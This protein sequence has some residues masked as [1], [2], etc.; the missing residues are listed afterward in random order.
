MSERTDEPEEK[1]KNRSK[2]IA[3]KNIV[4]KQNAEHNR[5]DKSKKIKNKNQSKNKAGEKTASESRAEKKKKKEEELTKLKKAN[6]A[7]ALLILGPR[8]S[9][10]ATVQVSTVKEA[11]ERVAERKRLADHLKFGGKCPKA[12]I[13]SHCK[14]RITELEN[15]IEDCS[16]G[17]KWYVSSYRLLELRSLIT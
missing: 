6:E 1:A 3:S 16:E 4:H 14:K 7:T 13:H 5:K 11:R 2:G 12:D 10:N 9:D 17:T 8:G 15:E